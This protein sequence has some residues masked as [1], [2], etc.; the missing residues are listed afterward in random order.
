[1]YEPDDYDAIVARYLQ[2]SGERPWMLFCRLFNARRLEVMP[3]LYAEDFVMV[4]RRKIAW[5]DV[6]GRDGMAAIVHGTLEIG[7]DQRSEAVTLEDSGSVAL[8]RNTFTGQRSG[9]LGMG[10]FEFVFDE[11]AVLRGGLV[12]RLELFDPSDEAA[13]RAR[14]EELRADLETPAARAYRQFADWFN[15]HRDEDPPPVLTDDY[16]MHDHRP[17]PWDSVHGP[18]AM[19]ELQRTVTA[20]GAIQAFQRLADDGGDVV[21][22]RLTITGA[23]GKVGGWELVIDHVTTLRDGRFASIEMFSP[24][25]SEARQARYEELRAAAAAG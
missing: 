11:V 24:D 4:D 13:A 19:I 3:S 5:E 14:Y 7:P 1:M 2:L 20:P 10:S 18:E 15:Y 9:E 12:A 25:Q 16:Q 17:M 6:V 22:Y 23:G 8:V 21:S